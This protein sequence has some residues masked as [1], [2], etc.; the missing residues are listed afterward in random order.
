[1]SAL[2][3]HAPVQARGEVRRVEVIAT[4]WFR[5]RAE[6]LAVRGTVVHPPGLSKPDALTLA[7]QTVMSRERALARA[8][9]DRY[10]PGSLKPMYLTHGPDVYEWVPA[11]PEENQRN[12]GR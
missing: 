6:R 7:H 2:Q 8:L 1:M 12:A 5:G 11:E 10:G 3:P 4:V 9:A